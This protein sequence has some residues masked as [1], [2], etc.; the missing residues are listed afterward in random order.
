MRGNA[1]LTRL[2]CALMKPKWPAKMASQ[3]FPKSDIHADMRYAYARRNRNPKFRGQIPL[4]F[5]FL[6]RLIQLRCANK[7]SLYFLFRYIKL[8]T[9]FKQR[10]ARAPYGE[11]PPPE[12]PHEFPP[13]R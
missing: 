6:Y 3:N 4:T 11:P 13:F 12:F 1:C 5:N 10:K 7:T 9:E 8:Q 2:T